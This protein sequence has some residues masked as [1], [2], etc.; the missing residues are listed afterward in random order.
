MYSSTQHCPNWLEC[1]RRSQSILIA[2]TLLY[3]NAKN[4]TIMFKWRCFFFLFFHYISVHSSRLQRVMDLPATKSKESK[5][6]RR[7]CWKG[8][9]KG[10][11]DVMPRSSCAVTTR[12]PNRSPWS[13]SKVSSSSVSALIVL[14]LLTAYL[15][16]YF[17]VSRALGEPSETMLTH[18]DSGICFT[19]SLL[20][21]AFSFSLD[22]SRWWTKRWMRVSLSSVLLQEQGASSSTLAAVLESPDPSISSKEA[23]RFLEKYKKLEVAVDAFYNDP[24]AMAA[25]SRRNNEGPSTSKLSQLFDK[26]KGLSYPYTPHLN[27]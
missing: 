20:D 6:H 5:P 24:S 8:R 16:F 12:L 15:F 17:T 23:K 25:A 22:S 13:S 2:F 14:S 11:A 4:L 10:V 27:R 18:V 3:P 26:Y 21:C 1:R 19:Y 7:G 9:E